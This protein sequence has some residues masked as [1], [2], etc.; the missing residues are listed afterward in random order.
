MTDRSKS[1]PN[2]PP[3]RPPPASARRSPGRNQSADRGWGQPM[4]PCKRLD[5]FERAVPSFRLVV[6]VH[7]LLRWTGARLKGGRARDQWSSL[8]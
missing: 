2:R 8:E 1:T 4:S 6:L 7:S 3:G 5:R